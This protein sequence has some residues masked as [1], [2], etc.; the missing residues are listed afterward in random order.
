MSPQA[1]GSETVAGVVFDLT[2]V[3]RTVELR[4]RAA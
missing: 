1:F 2:S 3:V 4:Y